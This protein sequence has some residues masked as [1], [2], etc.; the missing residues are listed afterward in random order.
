MATKRVVKRRPSAENL[1]KY[2]TEYLLN[3]SMR[4]KAAYWEGTLKGQLMAILEAVGQLHEGGHRTITL[5]EPVTYHEYKGEQPKVKTITGIERKCR[6]PA[7][8]LNE[9]RTMAYLKRKKL[10]DECTKTV[11][12]IDEDALLAHN[13]TGEITDK[14]LEALYDKGEPTYAFYLMEER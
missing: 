1:S 6:Q 11:V 14:E 10:M 7:L 12:V 9:E 3:R 2:V 8:T 13:F 4:D 5:D